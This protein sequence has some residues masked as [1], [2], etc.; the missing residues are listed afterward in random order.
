M[1]ANKKQINQEINHLED[2]IEHIESY[3]SN[4]GQNKGVIFDGIS[5]IKQ[6]I[7]HLSL[8]IN[9]K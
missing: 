7:Y 3:L 9:Q 4:G 8:L 6:S 5:S 2:A 1:K